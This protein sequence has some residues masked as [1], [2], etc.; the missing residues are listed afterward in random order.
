M[1]DLHP[2]ADG[3]RGTF[4]EQQN[5]PPLEAGLFA[6]SHIEK[7]ETE[8]FD[9]AP[10]VKYYDVADPKT[11]APEDKG[12]R[13]HSILREAIEMAFLY[14]LESGDVSILKPGQVRVFLRIFKSLANGNARD[15]DNW[16]T[17]DYIVEWIED[18]KISSGKYVVIT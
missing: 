11:N 18:V 3:T 6:M 1:V 8:D 14:C 15:Q 16:D 7:I 10:F 17:C 4:A 2:I 5:F 13:P 9:S 12:G